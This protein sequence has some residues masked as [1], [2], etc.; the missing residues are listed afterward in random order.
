MMRSRFNGV[1]CI[2]GMLWTVAACISARPTPSMKGSEGAGAGQPAEETRGMD[3]MTGPSATAEPPA[4]ASFVTGS[5]APFVLES[6]LRAHRVQHGQTIMLDEI[7][8][9]D[10]VMDG[11]RLQ[12]S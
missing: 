8:S 9:G 5:D 6:R 7:R 1:V 4:V 2:G 11:D 12:L 10:I 3:V